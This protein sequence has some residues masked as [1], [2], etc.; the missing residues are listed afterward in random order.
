MVNTKLP[1]E[2]QM[3]NTMVNTKVF[4]KKKNQFFNTMVNTKVFY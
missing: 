1:E 3:V 4:I 2:V